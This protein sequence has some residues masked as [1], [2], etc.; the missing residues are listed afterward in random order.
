VIVGEKSGESSSR[1]SSD[2][3]FSRPSRHPD[4][5]PVPTRGNYNVSFK[6]TAAESSLITPSFSK[7][8]HPLSSEMGFFLLHLKW[9]ESWIG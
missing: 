6:K 2:Q 9:Q 5:L 1:K 7:K 4:H 3:S 8:I